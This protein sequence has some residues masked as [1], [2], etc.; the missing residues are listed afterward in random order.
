MKSALFSC[1]RTRSPTVKVN[2]RRTCGFSLSL[3]SFSRKISE[4]MEVGG[5]KTRKT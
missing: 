4:S 5:D 3:V 1:S 2:S